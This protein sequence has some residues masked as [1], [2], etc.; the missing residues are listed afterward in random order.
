[1]KAL[2]LGLIALAIFPCWADR[3]YEYKGKLISYNETEFTLRCDDKVLR[4][5][6]SGVGSEYR[7]VLEKNVGKVIEVTS[8]LPAL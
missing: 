6:I 8:L 3:I 2:F 1:M 4:I 7:S 5:P